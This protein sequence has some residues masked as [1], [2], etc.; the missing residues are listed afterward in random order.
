MGRQAEV[1]PRLVTR[2]PHVGGGDR[3]PDDAILRA[4]PPFDRIRE[5]DPVGEGSGKP[6]RQPDVRVGL[7]QRGRDAP[8]P[9]G[10][11]HRPTDVP[12]GA[13]DDVR[14]ATAE[15]AQRGEGSTHSPRNRPQLAQA[16]PAR[17]ARDAERVELV[18]CFRNQPRLD[19]VRRPGERHASPA[20][21]QGVR[22]GERR[23]H[24]P[25]GPACCDQA[26]GL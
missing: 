5:E 26:H 19:A 8:Q 7:R 1:P 10:E 2:A 15:D 11:H 23:P 4:V 21:A 18:A 20:G 14:P 3:T 24:V 12:A 16:R 13:E 9:S 17:Q 25:G 6:V 22:D